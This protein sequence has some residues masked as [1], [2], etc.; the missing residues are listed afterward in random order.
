[1]EI[2]YKENKKYLNN[3]KLYIN[4]RHEMNINNSFKSN[5]MYK[6]LNLI[7]TYLY[8]K[9]KKLFKLIRYNTYKYNS[10]NENLIKNNKIIFFILLW[11]YILISLI[12][13]ILTEEI[14]DNNRKLEVVQS[15]NIKVKKIGTSEKLK[16]INSDYIPNKVYINGVISSI[17]NE[18]YVN[19]KDNL[20][21][22]NIT[23]EWNEKKEKYTKLFRN[24]ESLIEVDFTNFDSSRVTSIS[25]IFN[26]CKN[27]IYINFTNFNTSNIYDMSSMFENCVSLESIDLSNFDTS[28]VITMENMFKDCTSLTSLDL[29]SFHTPKLTIM[30]QMFTSC[31]SLENID[32]SSLDTS[33][34]TSMISLFSYCK[35]LISLDITNFITKKVIFMNELFMN[36]E[37]L[38]LIDLSKF[39]TSNALNMS[40]IFSECYSLISLNLSNFNTLKVENMDYMFYSC[41]SL[42]FLDVSSFDTSEVLSM[43]NMFS[44]C[45]SLISLDISN[46]DLS[47]KNLEQF[48]RN[49]ISL[50]SIKFSRKYKL[51]GKIDK[52]FSGCNSLTTLDLYNFDFGFVDNMEYLFSQCSS[53]TS[54]DL[55]SIDAFSVTSMDSMFYG[56]SSLRTLDIKKWNTASLSIINNMFYGCSSLTSLNLSGFKTSLVGEMISLFQN[57]NNLIS[58]DI[59][60]FDTSKVSEMGYMFYKCSSLTSIDLSNFNTSLVNYM[61]SM[62]FG[63]SNLTSLDLSNFNSKELYSVANMFEGC[64]NLEYINFSNFD[65]RNINYFYQAFKGVV[66]NLVYCVNNSSYNQKLRY[67]LSLIKCSINDCSIDWKKNKRK[68]IP[69][70]YMCIND[71]TLDDIYKYEYKDICYERCPKGTN[72]NKEN[73][74]LCELIV[75]ECFAKYPYIIVKNN[76]CEEECHSEDFFNDIC[77]INTINNKSQSDAKSILIS[78][79][80]KEIE[81]GTLNKLL[82]GVIFK[83]KNDIIKIS[84]DVLYQLTSSFNQK[85]NEYEN[86]T[87]INLG[88]FETILKDNYNIQ[89]SEALIIFK[90]EQFIED[91]YIPLIEYEIFNPITNEK[92]NLDYYKNESIELNIPVIINEINLFIHDPYNNYYN[93]ICNINTTEIGIDITLYDRQEE[94]NKDNLSLCPKNCNYNGYNSTNKKVSCLCQIQNGLSLSTEINKNE[95]LYNFFITKKSTNF[96]VLKCYKLLF[97]KRG[98][99]QNIGSYIILVIIFINIILAIIFC[100]KEYTIICNH[101]NDIVNARILGNNFDI[102]S[103]SDIKEEFKENSTGIF[104]SSKKT[105]DSILK[106]KSNKS[107]TELK[108]NSGITVNKNILNNINKNDLDKS[109]IEKTME[110]IDYEINTISYKEAIE[111][112]KRTYFQYYISL[113]KINHIL[114]FI[115]NRKKDYNSYAIKICLLF[116]SFALYMG[117]N[118]LFFNDSFMHR[119][120]LDKGIYNFKYALPKIIYSLLISSV[121]MII[122]RKIFLTHRNILEIKHEKNKFNLEVR[123]TIE[124]R[125]IKIKFIC[126]FIFSFLFLLLFWYYISSFCAVYKNTQIYMIKNTLISYSIE[127]IY[128]FIIY[129]LPGLF[130]ISAFKSPGK[131]LYKI[132]QIIQSL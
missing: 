92:F 3:E 13:P 49:S 114:M 19:I 50:I 14:S 10:K 64:I 35:K 122:F 98:L 99:I 116:F 28:N 89:L 37:S 53:L 34:V 26:N 80:I 68:I 9:V 81:D 131:C 106:K 87:S 67:E 112:D 41:E 30:N 66:D 119:I 84:N 127:L 4:N 25:N 58:I 108:T 103:K 56:C 27:L 121:I 61:D 82:S 110:Y 17:D 62:F 55:P 78:T 94:F 46:F 120:Y 43:K 76:T 57:C 12:N 44:E 22:Y 18:G 123:V 95:L 83:E 74:F 111:N 42:Q 21:D 36:C 7:K 115:F 96:D 2:N 129:L 71:C 104:S 8:L 86:I 113:V 33:S 75:N 48:F 40:Y 73:G 29:T 5:N 15:I 51:L 6:H 32:L 60:S 45:T 47:Q 1:M 117:V 107:V 54:L 63:C 20:P 130:R 59:S 132:S 88:E 128:P 124:L 38:E 77:S 11:K 72:S 69:D 109:E 101:I 85:N 24:I 31:E 93:D 90:I 65:D 91:L 16:I 70:K 97:S 126:F 79:I 100:L 118:T 105:K 102:S 52:M 23:L 125:N 39:D